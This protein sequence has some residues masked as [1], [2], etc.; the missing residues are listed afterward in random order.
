MHAPRHD[1]LYGLDLIRFA[2]AVL[3]A[4]FHLGFSTWA[5]P[6]SGGSKLIEGAYTLPAFAHF[7][8]FGWVGVQIFFVISGFVIANSANGATPMAFLRSRVLRLYPAVW[9]CVPLTALVLLAEGLTA[10]LRDK[11]IASMLLIPVGPWIDGQYWTL[12]VEIVFYA[13]VFSMLALGVFRWI[14]AFAVLLAAVSGVFLVAHAFFAD[15]D[16]LVEGK[17]RVLLLAH[18]VFFSLGILIWLW[19]QN[20]LSL[21]GHVAVAFA[22]FGAALQIR[23]HTLGMSER[24]T[25]SPFVIGE[26]WAVAVAVWAAS[27]LAIMLSFTMR[28]AFDRLSPGILS[29]IRAAGLATYPLYLLH[30]AIGV[31]AMREWSQAGLSPALGLFVVVAALS[32]A[33]WLVSGV[34]E[35]W[36]RG[37]LRKGFAWGEP[38][39]LASSRWSGF[40]YRS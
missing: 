9:V 24:V 10:N 15:L 38:R 27:C 12:G 39:L 30:F 32:A 14:E 13:C 26:Y 29:A 11:T 37:W 4:F 5:S 7:T 25:E 18:G 31:A 16:F 28:H 23:D 21:L 3:V 40:L 6:T 35:P 20:R 33:A 17:A 8:W 34:A 36:I 2:S 1:Y 22:T 19:S